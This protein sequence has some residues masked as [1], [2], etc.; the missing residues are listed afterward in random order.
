MCPPYSSAGPSFPHTHTR[1]LLRRRED[2]G[3]GRGEKVQAELFITSHPPFKSIDSMGAKDGEISPH[4][5]HMP[6]IVGES[7]TDTKNHP[8]N[9]VT[10]EETVNPEVN[11]VGQ[12][13]RK[14]VTPRPCSKNTSECAFGP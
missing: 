13:L 4:Y 5:T 3:G 2:K 6:A 11:S 12:G 10:F 7:T 1:L 8:K 14:K 9:M